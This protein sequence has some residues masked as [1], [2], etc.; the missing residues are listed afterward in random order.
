MKKYFFPLWV[1]VGCNFAILVFFLYL[2]SIGTAVDTMQTDTAA[3][4]SNFWNWT[5]LSGNVV[6]FM[7]VI[8][9]ELLA[10][11][12]TAKAFLAVK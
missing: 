1:F 7:L 8:M 3:I 12:A 5:W 2:S 6:K 10:L 9:L 4:A 11:Y